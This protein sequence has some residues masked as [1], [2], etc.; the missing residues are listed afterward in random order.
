M[1]PSPESRQ[2]PS[3]RESSNDAQ[4]TGSR[5]VVRVAL[6]ANVAIA[7]CKYVAAIFTG[8]SAMLAE[9]VHSTVDTGNELLLIFGFRRSVRP[10]SALHPFG[11]GKAYY[12]YSLL[13]AVYTF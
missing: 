2:S 12:F 5:R 13:V 3:R 1:P 4:A 7:I 8:S 10:P 11:H 9:A 6:I